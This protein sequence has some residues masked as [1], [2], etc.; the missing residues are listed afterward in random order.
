MTKAMVLAAGVGSRLEPISH[1]MPKPLVPVLNKPVISHI[2]SVLR[3]H[4]INQVISNT[5]YLADTLVNFFQTRPLTGMEL[6]FRYEA[7]LTGDAGGVRACRDFLE[8]ET[9]VVIM[10]DLIT[11]V[12]IGRLLKAH[13]EKG[14]LATIGVKAS[15]DVSRFGVVLRDEQG[16]IKGFQEKPKPEE[17]LSN[18][19]SAG[20]YI[21]EPEVFRH[22][23]ETGVYGF[24]RQLFPSLV[25]AGLPVLGEDIGGYWS[26]IG[27]LTDLFKANMDG[28]TGKISVR[29]RV[30]PR[31]EVFPGVRLGKDVLIGEHV[32]IGAGSVIG[33]GSIIGDGCSIAENVTVENCVMFAECC[34]P[35]GAALRNCIY[36]FDEL[37]SIECESAFVGAAGKER[38]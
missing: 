18:E 15:E 31:N 14:A 23:P 27:T 11:D 10:G 7:E 25:S 1:Y 35:A 33:E 26:D 5:H 29:K 2:L 12:D 34:I 3:R 16:F 38:S 24:G 30:R 28:L 32:K 8:D 20:I 13:R 21:L 6:Q 22:I 37:I 4:G 9:F 19:I 36:A 17:A